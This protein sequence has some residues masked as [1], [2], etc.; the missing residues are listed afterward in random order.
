ML[1][2]GAAEPLGHVLAG[3][4]VHFVAGF[5]DGAGQRHGQH[6][7]DQP[8]DGARRQAD[9]LAEEAAGGLQVLVQRVEPGRG[10]RC[11]RHAAEV[12]P[13]VQAGHL[14]VRGELVLSASRRPS[15]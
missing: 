4:E 11:E 3:G 12:R 10:Q 6:G 15:R 1:G 2:D 9:A 13:D 8:P 14:P 5:G 7:L